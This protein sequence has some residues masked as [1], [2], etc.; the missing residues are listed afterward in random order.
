LA[1]SVI[2]G[3]CEEEDEEEEVE[4]DDEDEEGD[5]FITT[6]FLHKNARFGSIASG[7]IVDLMLVY[8]VALHLFLA[9]AKVVTSFGGVSGGETNLCL[10]LRERGRSKSR[11]LFVCLF[12][13][14]FE[15][16]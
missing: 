12:V 4:E 3:L 11:S 2:N 10:V 5:L 1:Q 6:R 9:I 14:S 8:L 15:W 7:T 16:L 13:R